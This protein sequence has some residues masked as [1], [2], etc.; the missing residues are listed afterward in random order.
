ML[1]E[2]GLVFILPRYLSF[3][4]QPDENFGKNEKTEVEIAE[5]K[6]APQAGSSESVPEAGPPQALASLCNPVNTTPTL[7]SGRI[8]YACAL[9]LGE[10]WGFCLWWEGVGVCVFGSQ[11]GS[12][13]RWWPF[14]TGAVLGWGGTQG[15]DMFGFWSWT[16]SPAPCPV[17]LSC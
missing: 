12:S 17:Q 10:Q 7:K 3:R 11:G 9:L 1:D 15:L 8:V 13:A 4:Y 14:L 6:P 2:W 16:C 5:I